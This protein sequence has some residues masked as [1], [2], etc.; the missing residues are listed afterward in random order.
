MP[1]KVEEVTSCTA[2]TKPL[3][4]VLSYNSLFFRRTHATFHIILI[5]KGPVKFLTFLPPV[6]IVPEAP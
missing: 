2:T 3:I 5:D 4:D 6:K 1:P